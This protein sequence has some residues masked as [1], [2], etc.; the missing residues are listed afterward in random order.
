MGDTQAGV[1][2]AIEGALSHAEEGG[3]VSADTRAGDSID[4]E[5]RSFE[6]ADSA[7]IN[8]QGAATPR[9]VP[10]GFSVGD[11]IGDRY[12]VKQIYKGGMGLVYM[13]Y[14]Q[15][16][17]VPVT[18]KTFQNR[19][20]R[21]EKATARF[22]QEAL[23]WIRLEKY[24]H[25]VQ[26]L[27]VQRFNNRPHI[28]LESIVGPEGLGP[29]LSSWIEHQRL[30][31][32]TALRFGLQICLGMQYAVKQVPGLVH[33]DLKPANILVRYDGIAKITDFGLVRS[34]NGR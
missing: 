11:R 16:T 5:L 1:E 22:T 2:N 28:I 7:E 12:E 13:C 27:R 26:A 34:L 25:I 14:D 8:R 24:Q 32:E 33:R 21:N 23:T 17:G 30:N 10:D 19:F 18:L 6:D 31:L 4:I 15:D 20:L 29:D 9:E 3:W